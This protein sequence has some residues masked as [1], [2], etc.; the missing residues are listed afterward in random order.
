MAT[1]VLVHGAWAGSWVWKKVIPLLRAGGHDVYASTAT[2]MGD[3]VHL[4]RPDLDLDAYVTDVV[5]L[6]AFEDL[7][8]VTLVG[9]SHGG[10]TI[11]GVAERVP[12]CLRQLV[13]LD[14]AVP[15]DGEDTF[16]ALRLPDQVRA[17]W[18]AAAEAAGK[19]GYVLPWADYIRA[20][21]KDPVDLAWLLAK[22]V[23][24]PMASWTQP[25]RLG[26]PAAAALPRAF[27]FCLEGW[28]APRTDGLAST[29]QRVKAD[30]TWR[31]RQ[32]ADNH[33]APVNS[34]QATA[35]VLLSLV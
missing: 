3:R 9:W 22:S 17:G 15:A 6:L 31:Y 26:N 18:V 32:V 23:P 20:L 24:Q 5:N 25:I 34:P 27:V 35:D 33:F 30:P 7:T 1:F 14:A 13:Y 12:A 8:D 11:T 2:G 10:M 29:A 19:T 21:T 16:Q 28:S 4:A